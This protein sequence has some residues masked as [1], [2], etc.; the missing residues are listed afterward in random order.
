[1]I[2][3]IILL[4]TLSFLLAGC[5]QD[6]ELLTI[7][8]W[9]VENLFDL[10][11]NP[12]KNDEEFALNGRKNM[13]QEI[14]DLKLDHMSEVLTDL[15]ADV[16]GLCEVENLD[17]LKLLNAHYTKRNYD[18]IHYESPDSRGIDVAL[19]YDSKRLQV[20]DS[21]PISIA[22]DDGPPT[23]DI[24]YVRGESDGVDLHLFVNHWPSNYIGKELA[25]PRRIKV[26]K[27]L[28]QEIDNILS[29]NSQ[30]EI[31]LMGDFNENPGDTAV[32]T[33]LN[34]ALEQDHLSNDPFTLWNAMGKF[35]GVKRGGTYV[36]RGQDSILDHVIISSGLLDD[37]GLAMVAESIRI[38]DAPKYRQ[39]EG[40]Y[41]GYPFRFWAG[42]NLLGGY[43]D[44]LAVSIQL[45]NAD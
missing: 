23:R 24:L 28:R 22:F 8:F 39:Q 11:D 32:H 25:I 7:S 20:I 6:P 4:F 33:V 41:Q 27:V 45:Q 18:I 10:V 1:M 35:I 3:R 12:E 16:L 9:N 34:T 30:A 26:A 14:L 36:Y 29:V 42:D 44:H 37:V 21:K 38:N 13:T 31:L 19:L 15:N 40:D 5:A 43:S 17:V 2:N